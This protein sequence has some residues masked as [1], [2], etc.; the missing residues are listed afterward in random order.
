MPERTFE[1]RKQCAATASRTGKRCGQYAL[2]GSDYCGMHKS[3]GTDADGQTVK[4]GN[5]ICKR[6]KRMTN[7]EEPDHLKELRSA[8]AAI[9]A[10]MDE[11]LSRLDEARKT[12]SETETKEY[13]SALESHGKRIQSLAGELFDAIE[14]LSKVEERKRLL[15]TPADVKRLFVAIKDRVVQAVADEG[16]GA[17][18][19]ALAERIEAELESINMEDVVER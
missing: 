17:E 15:L 13:S 9:K 2:K 12:M 5:G 18:P 11:H 10:L 3:H 7:E 1:A 16:A 19:E 8:V 4:K 6:V 14:K